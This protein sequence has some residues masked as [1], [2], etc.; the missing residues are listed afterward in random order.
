MP[1]F[2]TTSRAIRSGCSTA[3]RNPI[4][5]PQSWTTSVDRGVELFG[6][7]LDDRVVRVVRVPVALR[8]LVGPAEAEVVG[9][10]ARSPPT[11]AAE[12]LA[13]RGSSTSARRAGAA[14]ARPVPRRRSASAGRPG[15]GSAARTATLE[16]RR[17]VRRASGRRS[18][19]VGYDSARGA[20]APD[21]RNAGVDEV[22]APAGGAVAEV[23]VAPLNPIDISDGTGRFYGGSPDPPYVI[24]SEGVGV[25]DGRRVWF[26]GNATAAERA[27]VDEARAVEVPR[28]RRRCDRRGLRNRRVT[29]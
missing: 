3:S 25:L 16:G 23:S 10:D 26:R 12:S 21:R 9:R 20:V 29:G 19:L 27:L 1:V 7:A 17:S 5:P 11:R 13:G 18:S 2:S 8:R 15:P 4:G 14:R 22:E 6:E 28:R 24:G